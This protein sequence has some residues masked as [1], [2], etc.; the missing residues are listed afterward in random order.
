MCI[1]YMGENNFYPPVRVSTNLSE[2]YT[3]ESDDEPGTDLQRVSKR[4]RARRKS[5]QIPTENIL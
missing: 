5:Q 1:A 4:A 3:A 2:D